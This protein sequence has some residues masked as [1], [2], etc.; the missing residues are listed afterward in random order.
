MKLH[1]S[2]LIATLLMSLSVFLGELAKTEYKSQM[3]KRKIAKSALMLDNTTTN[4]Q[5]S[6][7]YV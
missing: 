1:C 5:D 3:R 4:T 7:E 2:T 6:I